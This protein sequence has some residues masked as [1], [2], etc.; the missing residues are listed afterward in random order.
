M[1]IAAVPVHTHT[2]SSVEINTPFIHRKIVLV[3][4]AALSWAAG[5]SILPLMVITGQ[6]GIGMVL[7]TSGFILGSSKL[8][9]HIEETPLEKRIQKIAFIVLGAAFFSYGALFVTSLFATL[10]VFALSVDS[11]ATLNPYA[12]FLTAELAA[13]TWGFLIPFT[14]TLH[15]QA[16]KIFTSIDDNYHKL[17]DA[18]KFDL[19]D[20]ACFLNLRPILETIEVVLSKK[21]KLQL[22][23][24]TCLSMDACEFESFLSQISSRSFTAKELLEVLEQKKDEFWSKCN[25]Y[26]TETDEIIRFLDNIPNLVNE[27]ETL[28][29]IEAVQ[30][31]ISEKIQRAGKICELF[32]TLS[33]NPIY[34]A[35]K[36]LLK[37]ST[38]MVKEHNWKT[39]L[40]TKKGMLSSP[41]SEH[42]QEDEEDLW[43]ALAYVVESSSCVS[44]LKE[45][46]IPIL[47]QGAFYTLDQ[48]LERCGLNSVA[49]LK[50]A[51]ILPLVKSQE[52]HRQILIKKIKAAR[53]DNV[54][55]SLEKLVRL[56]IYTFSTISIW[57]ARLFSYAEN[58]LIF[59]LGFSVALIQT[60]P[61]SIYEHYLPNAVSISNMN[62]SA[63]LARQYFIT[64]YLNEWPYSSGYLTGYS[65][66][67]YKT[68]VE[69]YF[70]L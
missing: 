44:I 18:E 51:G 42:S 4:F 48:E 70:S 40:L 37:D 45:L 12:I 41:P 3:A 14:R 60:E 38:D 16:T 62:D 13:A 27:A 36:N 20:L 52:F 61:F 22:W 35:K 25:P 17:K 6:T 39:R 65:V 15:T 2:T 1:S 53:S 67:R 28:K 43:R 47:L 58:P 24:Y 5:G 7:L 50:E 68:R 63:S 11:L 30:I 56:A 55:F 23:A 32:E 26:L 34:Q 57:A 69:R 29:Q 49:K 66:R 19:K 9:T 31:K 46:G 8:I 21:L 64:V 59:S 10:E 33:C 54:T